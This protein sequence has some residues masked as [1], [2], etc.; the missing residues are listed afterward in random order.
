MLTLQLI[1]KSYDIQ[2]LRKIERNKIGVEI[3]GT[4]SLSSL[5]KKSHG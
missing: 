4:E 3:F 2:L 5:P 1:S